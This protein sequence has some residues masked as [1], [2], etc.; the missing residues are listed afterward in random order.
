[1]PPICI[2]AARGHDEVVQALCSQKAIK[3]GIDVDAMGEHGAN[4]LMECLTN[5]GG[6]KA[7]KIVKLLLDTD[8]VDVNRV[9]AKGQTA[10]NIA[11][12]KCH[13]ETMRMLLEKGAGASINVCDEQFGVTPLHRAAITGSQK[14]CGA[15]AVKLL[16]AFEGIDINK[17]SKSGRTALTFAMS[18]ADCDDK[19]EMV[20]MLMEAGAEN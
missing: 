19:Q 17:K 7:E 12:S 18:G 10:L 1:M 11:A 3:K 8:S 6:A 15:P 5:Q 16:L 14:H 13:V 4:A 20:R 2:A 9:F